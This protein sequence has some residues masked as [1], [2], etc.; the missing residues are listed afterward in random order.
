MPTRREKLAALLQND[1]SDP[2]LHYAL[3]MDFASAGEDAAA[4]ARLEA[5]SL[6]HPDYIPTYLQGGQLYIKLD[7]QDQARAML[8]QGIERAQRLGD[9]HAAGEMQGFLEQ[10]A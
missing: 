2:F 6:S 3:A 9:D 1:P 4:V 8:T 7:Q 5:L 10:L